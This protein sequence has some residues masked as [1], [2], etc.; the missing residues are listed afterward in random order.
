MRRNQFI[1]PTQTWLQPAHLTTTTLPVL[2]SFGSKYQVDF[3]ENNSTFKWE[4]KENNH[5]LDFLKSCLI[6]YIPHKYW[7]YRACYTEVNA[8]LNK[9]LVEKVTP[10]SHLDWLILDCG[11]K[12]QWLERQNELGSWQE[13]D[14]ENIRLYIYAWALSQKVLCKMRIRE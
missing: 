1:C 14:V 7:Q 3:M 13:E 10:R 2:H 4:K 9:T 6:Q 11:G 5:C 12:G 8:F